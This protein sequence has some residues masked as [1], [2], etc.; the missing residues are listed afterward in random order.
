MPSAILLLPGRLSTLTGGTIYDRRIVAG[1]RRRGWTIDVVE[2]DESCPEPT[3][4]ALDDAARAF[5]AIPDGRIA[6]VD[7]LAFG[8]LPQLA[9]AHRRRLSLVALVHMPLAREVGIDACTARRR[10]AA[11]RRSLACAV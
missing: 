1:L 2:L 8:A 9:E 11:E 3:A 7:G 10:E 5:A 4:A 6:I